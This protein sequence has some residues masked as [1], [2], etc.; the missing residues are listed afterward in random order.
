MVPRR[1][2]L[3]NF[4]SYGDTFV[5]VDFTGWQLGCL[6]GNNG[7]GKSALL[8][9]MTWVVWG[10]SR[11]KREDDV[12]RQGATDCE[13]EL[14][15]SL[16]DAIYRALRKRSLRRS[17]GGHTILEFSAW[18]GSQ[19]RPLSADSVR[20]TEARILATVRLS[21]ET[22]VN[23]AF[24]RQGHAD[25]FTQKSAGDRKEILATIL[26]LDQYDKLQ[27]IARERAKTAARQVSELHR[28]LEDLEK[29]IAQ[30]P[31][32]EQRLA[33]LE[34][35]LLAATSAVRVASED[36]QA[37]QSFLDSLGQLAARRANLRESIERRRSDI[38]RDAA[39]LTQCER[40]LANVDNLIEHAVQIDAAHAEAVSLRAACLEWDRK[41]DTLHHL[42]AQMNE[43]VQIRHT[44]AARQQAAITGWRSEI[45]KLRRQVAGL[46]DTERRLAAAQADALLIPTLESRR[47]DIQQQKDA[48]IAHQATLQMTVK[49]LEDEKEPLRERLRLLQKSDAA[50]PVCRTPLDDGRRLSLVDEY[51]AR[52]L[53]LR[54][55]SD[56]AK[57]E[58]ANVV[59]VIADLTNN[60]KILAQ[61]LERARQAHLMASQWA[62]DV[63]RMHATSQDITERLM[64]VEQEQGILAADTYLPEQ[65][66]RII[67][68]QR[69]I[70]D[71]GYD[72]TAH[73]R[74]QSRL[75]ELA[76]A[77]AR[78]NDLRLATA[79]QTDLHSQRA[80][81]QEALQRAR[82]DVDRDEQDM[83]IIE[84]QLADIPLHEQRLHAA[85]ERWQEA[86]RLL[87]TYGEE[88]GQVRMLLS[89]VV[90]SAQ[91]YEEVIQQRDQATED[92]G[93]YNDLDRAFGRQGIQA[94]LIDSALPQIE[95]IA[96]ELLAIMSDSG[97]SV[98]LSTQ[99]TTQKGTTA[100]TLDILISD[101]AGTR[102]YE[103]YSGGEAFRVNLAIRIAIS[104]LLAARAGARLQT[105]IIDEGFG[106]QDNQGI[107]RLVEAINSIAGRFDKIIVITHLSEM[108]ELFPVRLEVV[109]GARGSQ[110]TLIE[111]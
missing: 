7:H 95:N 25:E 105:L 75:V 29:T 31:V 57:T 22:F 87:L 58:L 9:A 56:D 88:R 101:S 111:S 42:Q 48:V 106:T 17:M 51:K 107:E 98:R 20:S 2:R 97:L 3:R 26:G 83:R 67:E 74:A 65:S 41:K 16:G 109:K 46:D 69:D 59:R 28:T 108:K 4:M 1:L 11:A 77:E 64:Q 24:L 70:A 53:A 44:H 110:V 100:E 33:A 104:E 35:L 84:P 94:M 18:D 71:L 32:Y 10:Q 79:R 14:E 61:D 85:R 62:A 86:E 52:G 68:L 45:D 78:W 63:A 55:Q 49:N 36:T 93:L 39:R 96:N 103:M 40:D 27:R 50:C 99:R 23:T 8:D 90:E 43:A 5:E 47:Q 60:D 15:F 38:V 102:Q 80:L 19:F 73:S 89:S 13:V 6:S 54:Q 92:T 81:I 34:E 72:Q 30:K 21:Y 12:V 37:T 82:A 66:A 91:R 76:A